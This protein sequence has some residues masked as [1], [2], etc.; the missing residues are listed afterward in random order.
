MVLLSTDI[1]PISSQLSRSNTMTMKRG[2]RCG[3]YGQD[4]P[5]PR[6]RPIRAGVPIAIETWFISRNFFCSGG[7][8]CFANS[9]QK[10]E[11]CTT[12]AESPK[13]EETDLC[14]LPITLQV[15][16]LPNDLHAPQ[17]TQTQ[18]DNPRSALLYLPPLFQQT[19]NSPSEGFDRIGRQVGR[20]MFGSR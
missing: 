4:I 12:R 10:S 7:F 13:P 3:V 1:V 8:I 17:S 2:V 5:S 6:N 9:C 11:R 19:R 20:F 14:D 16:H 18:N 15:L